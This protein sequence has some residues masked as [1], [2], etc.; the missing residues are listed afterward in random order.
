MDKKEYFVTARRKGKKSGFFGSD[1]NSGNTPYDIE[2][3]A[4]P[5]PYHD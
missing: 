3:T 5:C 4:V 1:I 2:E